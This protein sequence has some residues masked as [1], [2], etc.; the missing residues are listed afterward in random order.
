VPIK[1]TRRNFA[2]D[3]AR[4]VRDALQDA[5]GNFEAL[6]EQGFGNCVRLRDQAFTAAGSARIAHRLKRVPRGWRVIR[7]RGAAARLYES[8]STEPDATH[9]TLF[10]E[11][12]CTVDL[13]FW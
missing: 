3:T 11:T 10:S 1:T 9:I 6:A 8:S 5:A 4:E 7:A 12:T 2:S 13:E